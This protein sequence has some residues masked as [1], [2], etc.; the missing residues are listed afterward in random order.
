[1]PTTT[2]IIRLLLESGVGVKQSFAEAQRANH[3]ISWPT[4]IQ[5]DAFK[6]SQTQLEELVRTLKGGGLHDAI[7]VVRKKEDEI[8]EGKPVKELPPEKLTQY[9]GLVDLETAL[10]ARQVDQLETNQDVA[11]WLVQEVLPA[12]VRGGGIALKLLA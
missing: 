1:M 9:S 5:S 7:L 8:L 10:A 11:S 12:L 3:G 4:F 6:S 2:E